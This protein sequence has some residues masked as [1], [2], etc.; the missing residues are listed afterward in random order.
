LNPFVPSFFL[1]AIGLQDFQDHEPYH[2][3]V[4]MSDSQSNPPF[5][6]HMSIKGKVAKKSYDRI[7]KFQTEWRAKMQ[8]G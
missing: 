2:P 4:D 1:V 7:G 3:I 6:K 5:K 8:H